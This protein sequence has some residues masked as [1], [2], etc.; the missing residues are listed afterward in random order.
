MGTNATELRKKE[1]LTEARGSRRIGPLILV[2]LIMMND[3]F[4][5]DPLRRHHA[6]RRSS[7]HEWRQRARKR[8][9]NSCALCAFCAL[10][11][12]SAAGHAGRF[13]G[14]RAARP[15]GP[16]RE[17]KPATGTITH[18]KSENIPPKARASATF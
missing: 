8:T 9:A 4:K 11:G 16:P 17:T 2:F 18:P 6:A 3:L 14:A 10:C 15:N 13:Y 5:M 12:H 7:L 1:S